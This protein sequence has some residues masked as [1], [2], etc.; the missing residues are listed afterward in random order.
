MKTRECG[1]ENGVI[2]VCCFLTAL[3]SVSILQ[4]PCSTSAPLCNS[5]TDS[6]GRLIIAKVTMENKP[7]FILNI[8][9][10]TDYRYQ[11][12]FI[13]TISKHQASKTDN[14]KVIISGDWN[15][16]LNPIDKNGGQPW[17]ATNYRNVLVSVTERNKSN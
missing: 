17:K 7:F 12:N 3:R 4:N 16:T 15:T 11:D 9:A 6:E 2:I 1:L 10:P 13:K 14:S 5:S 8:S